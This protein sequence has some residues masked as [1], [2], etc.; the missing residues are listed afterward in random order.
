MRRVLK[1]SCLFLSLILFVV[2]AQTAKAAISDYPEAVDALSKC[3]KEQGATMY[4][5]AGCGHCNRQKEMFGS[6]FRNVRYVDCRSSSKNQKECNEAR[7]G[8][9]PQWNFPNGQRIVREADLDTIAAKSGCYDYVASVMEGVPLEPKAQVEYAAKPAV[10]KQA[11]ASSSKPAVRNASNVASSGSYGSK[12]QLA[13]CLADK[14]VKFY[15]S[16]KCGHCNRQ[17]EM[18]EGAFEQYLSSNFHNCKGSE[19]ERAECSKRGTFPFPTWV[20]PSTGV[21]LPG[22]ERSLE[23]I[24]RTFGCTAS[25]NNVKEASY[26]PAPIQQNNSSSEQ[27]QPVSNQPAEYNEVPVNYNPPAPESSVNSSRADDQ[28]NQL[29]ASASSSAYDQQKAMLIAK[30]NKLAA[31]LVNKN[32]T[33]YGITDANNGKPIQFRATYQQLQ[34]LGEAAKKVKIVDCSANQAECSGILV[35]PTWVLDGKKELAGVYELSNLAQIIG[36]PIEE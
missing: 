23:Q 27:V 4:G 28:N 33:L 21:K 7:V 36:C 8:K 20:E 10:V 2:T 5:T 31:C 9:F 15:G 34:E 12:E 16:P 14:G 26:E 6:A 29:I 22:P 25:E 17:K 18:F 1:I 32:I 3:L 11:N 24:A 13:K 35:Y 19:A 30:Q